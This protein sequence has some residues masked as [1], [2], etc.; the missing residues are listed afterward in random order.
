MVYT[1]RNRSEAVAMPSAARKSVSSERGFLPPLVS[2]FTPCIFSIYCALWRLSVS[3][4]PSCASI[5]RS[6]LTRDESVSSICLTLTGSCDSPLTYTIPKHPYKLWGLVIWWIWLGGSV[7]IKRM[8][9]A[10][11][12]SPPASSMRTDSPV[13]SG[14]FYVEP[15][16]SESSYYFSILFIALTC[17][18]SLTHRSLGG[19][20]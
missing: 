20:R 2:A 19:G 6:P 1:F 3:K 4:F 16:Y 17:L 5:V 8:N 12:V 11:L 14:D 13:Y 18:L 10:P 15:F 9:I 7:I